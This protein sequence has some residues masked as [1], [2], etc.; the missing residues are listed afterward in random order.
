M[1]I[2]HQTATYQPQSSRQQALIQRHFTLLQ[3]CKG[4]SIIAAILGRSYYEHQQRRKMAASVPSRSHLNLEKISDPL[5][6]N[7]LAKLASWCETANFAQEGENLE[8]C[9]DGK[10]ASV[11]RQLLDTLDLEGKV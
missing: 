8:K 6:E 5:T 1:S 3:A 9:V 4:L 10:L 11:C 2:A 7:L